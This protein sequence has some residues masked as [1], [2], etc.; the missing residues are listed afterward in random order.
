MAAQAHVMLGAK[1]LADRLRLTTRESA[2]FGHG[3]QLNT[4][5]ARHLANI[6]RG[7]P[8]TTKTG[9]RRQGAMRDFNLN[10][11][12]PQPCAPV[13]QR[14]APD[15]GPRVYVTPRRSGFNAC[16][17]AS[18]GAS[19]WCGACAR[20]AASAPGGRS[21]AMNNWSVGHAA[22]PS[23]RREWTPALARPSVGFPAQPPAADSRRV[24]SLWLSPGPRIALRQSRTVASP[25]RG[26]FPLARRN[27][28]A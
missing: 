5:S 19:I 28:R 22:S 15:P 25:W 16:H 9:A 13:T 23:S 12:M 27:V 14:R 11:L 7:S 24:T 20:R 17:A 2:W 4:L 3:W 8:D 26:A 10:C 6:W 21:I 1:A 18:R